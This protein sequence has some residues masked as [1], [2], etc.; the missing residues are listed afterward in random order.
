MKNIM[1]CIFFFCFC[2]SCKKTEVSGVV[3]SVSKIPMANVVVKLNDF[4]DHDSPSSPG[5]DSNVATTDNNG[6]YYY[7]F[8]AKNNHTYTIFCNTNSG[9]VGS[10]LQK[11]KANNVDIY[12]K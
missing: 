9:N 2:I 4:N 12:L 11:D 6:Y 3:Y 7:S 1:F 5:I 8:K 10:L